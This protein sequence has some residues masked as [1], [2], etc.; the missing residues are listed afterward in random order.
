M[1]STKYQWFSYGFYGLALNDAITAGD[2]TAPAVASNANGSAFLAAWDDPSAGGS[3]EGRIVNRDSFPAGSQFAINSTGA[4]NQTDASI[5]GL[6]NGQ[7]ITTFTDY[8]S[9][10]AGDIRAHLIGAGGTPIGADFGIATGSS[11][12]DSQSDVAAL[13]D[14]GYVVTW[15]RDFGA[16][17]HDIHGAILEANGSFR[18]LNVNINDNL[19]NTSHASV[20]ALTGGG[21]VTAWEESPAGGGNTEVR[22]RLFD[23]HGN[24]LNGAHD[25]GVLIDN[26]GSVNRDI[27]V[28]GLQDGGFAVAYTDN[29][30]SGTNTDITVKVFNA[31]G[32]ARSSF[33]QANSAANGGVAAG[34]QSLPSLTVLSNG[35]FVVGWKDSASSLE[36]VQ[37][38]DASGHAI[39]VNETLDY[40]VV[41][42]EIV[43][44][45]DGHLGVVTETLFP[46]TS[47]TSLRSTVDYLSRVI[48]GDNT[49]ETIHGV[50]DKLAETILALGGDDVIT[51]GNGRDYIEGGA[52]DD[53]AVFS[54]SLDKYTLTDFGNRIVVSGPDGDDVLFNVEHL[55][56]SDG[57]IT[58]EDGNPLFDT[59]YYMSHNLDVFHAGVNA[60]DHF[61][62]SGWHEGRDPSAFFDTS[63]YLAVNKDVAAAG[64]NPLDHYHQSGWHEGRDP[65]ADFD[66]TLYLARNPDVAAAGIDPLE[67]YLTVGMAQ[68]R[69][70]YQAIGQTIVN[71]FDAE[72]YLLHNP[73][74]A[75]AGVDPLTH[76]NTFGWHEGRNPN[77]YFD[78]AGYL[79]HYSDVAASGVNPLQHYEQFG[80]HEGRDPSA[81]F[82]TLGYLA[83]NPDVAAAGV[84]PLDHF[85]QNGIYEGRSGM[86]DGLWH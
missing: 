36:Y 60:L 56:F 15:T 83:A 13:A 41:E 3:V 34:D 30:W 78:T 31:D 48:T 8:S 37:A 9:D 5:A 6:K 85:L 35:F 75:A 18:T 54:Q 12:H 20:A 17:D 32:S 86:G 53:T 39:G 49:S 51:G 58:P 24:G 46:D 59:V 52:G 74:V 72:Y 62:T 50:N 55:Q 7:F 21:F 19:H 29:G 57:T 11:F 66:T 47:G 76:F 71:G 81:G 69:Q 28:A 68:G 16:G 73:D 70:A 1:A 40:G 44:L 80:W 10:P 33:L 67:H 64:V 61:N 77:A 23:A 45:S 4:G 43:G 27:Q 82:D 26:F 38:Y 63:G 25:V 79:S 42:T 84:N 14:G 2:Q 65:G 22:F